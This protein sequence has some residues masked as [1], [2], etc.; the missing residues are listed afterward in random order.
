MP[1]YQPSPIAPGSFGSDKA[2]PGDPSF[3]HCTTTGCQEAWGLGLRMIDPEGV[4]PQNPYPL[5]AIFLSPSRLTILDSNAR[6][7]VG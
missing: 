3:D 7:R 5:S 6:G 2:F 1:Y 4:T